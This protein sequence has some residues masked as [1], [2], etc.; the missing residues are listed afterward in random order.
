[1]RD[2]APLNKVYAERL[3]AVLLAGAV[4]FATAL[5]VPQVGVVLLRLIV[6]GALGLGVLV[7]VTLV[8]RR[9]FGPGMSPPV[10]DP[11]LPARDQ[12]ERAVLQVAAEN[13]GYVTPE[14]V[15]Q[16][17]SGLTLRSATD[18]LEDLASAGSCEVE[19]DQDGRTVYRFRTGVVP[20]RDDLTPEQWVEQSSRRL[21]GDDSQPLDDRADG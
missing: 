10:H 3:L 12:A 5:L 2:R 9:I 6:G 21:T 1:M 11:V 15:V 19:S 16:C 18:L 20:A 17:T 4:A 14:A 7:P 13:D 8:C